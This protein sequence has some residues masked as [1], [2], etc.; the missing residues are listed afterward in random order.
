MTQLY[1]PVSLHIF[2]RPDTTKKVFAQIRKIRPYKL[3]ITADGPRDNIPNDFDKCEETRS[4]VQNIDWDCEVFTNFSRLNKGSYKTTSQGISWVFDYVDRAIILEDDCIPDLS[5]FKFCEELL[6]YYLHDTRIALISGN[7]FQIGEK[8]NMYSYY[9]SRYTHIWGWATWKRTWD[10]VGAALEHWPEFRDANGLDT[11]F[12]RR[13]ERQYW[14][15]LYQELYKGKRGPHW[16]FNLLLSSFMNNKFSILPNVNLVS[17]IGFGKDTANCK[18]KSQFHSL[19]TEKM[20]FPLK[21][22]PNLYR[23]AY[24]DKFTEQS[25]FSGLRE[26][27]LLTLMKKVLMQIKRIV[28]W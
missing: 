25:I 27:R 11:I 24:A 21:H 17:N 28:G 5:F 8:E 3:F 26:N 6:D 23:N 22:P 7:N 10:Q 12:C 18:H 19:K 4:I 15:Q 2:N 13:H 14:H 9:F 20:L 16:D 1:T